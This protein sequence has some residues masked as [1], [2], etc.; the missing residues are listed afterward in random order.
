MARSAS[1]TAAHQP[2]TQ[3]VDFEIDSSAAE[4]EVALDAKEKPR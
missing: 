2:Q 1:P 4:E 3:E